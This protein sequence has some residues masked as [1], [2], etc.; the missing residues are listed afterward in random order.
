M[1][2]NQCILWAQVIFYVPRVIP[3]AKQETSK[4]I[5]NYRQA[6]FNQFLDQSDDLFLQLLPSY[7]LPSAFLLI[8]CYCNY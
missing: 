1:L 4:H 6:M 3:I 7:K 8:F 2:T 5:T